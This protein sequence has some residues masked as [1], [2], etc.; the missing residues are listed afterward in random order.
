MCAGWGWWYGCRIATTTEQTTEVYVLLENV[1]YGE[2]KV[3]GVYPSLEAA[4]SAVNDDP[5]KD[6]GD[7][8][9]AGGSFWSIARVPLH[10]T[11]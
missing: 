1:D 2:E 3:V 11:P 5:W 9:W 4:Q 7:G 10:A 8:T 6:Y